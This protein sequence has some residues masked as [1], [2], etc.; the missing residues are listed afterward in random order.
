MSCY[1]SDTCFLRWRNLL[2]LVT[3]S[4][5]FGKLEVGNCTFKFW[6]QGCLRLWAS[7]LQSR[8]QAMLGKQAFNVRF[9][10]TS[11]QFLSRKMRICRLT[12][13]CCVVQSWLTCAWLAFSISSPASV[14]NVG[15]GT[16]WVKN[17]G[18]GNGVP[19]VLW[20]FNHCSPPYKS[21]S[22]LV[23]TMPG[24]ADKCPQTGQNASYKRTK[25]KG[26]FHQTTNSKYI[27]LG[28]LC[29]L[30]FGVA[31]FWGIMLGGIVSGYYVWVYLSVPR[32]QQVSS[33]WEHDAIRVS[34]I[35]LQV[36]C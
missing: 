5:Y 29:L 36:W 24:V 22:Y 33:A 3:A 8:P 30:I 7:S 34:M 6:S 31:F 2:H 17:W 28:A 35:I 12:V 13:N 11:L 23:S 27:L 26:P 9:F 25:R 14:G 18:W 4:G 21:M 20:H 32:H 10:F 15:W 1:T 16:L 19:C